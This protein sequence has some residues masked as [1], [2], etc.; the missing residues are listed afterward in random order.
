M[1]RTTLFFLLSILLVLQGLSQCP[2]DTAVN[3]G[4]PAMGDFQWSG[5]G[6]PAIGE[7]PTCVTFDRFYSWDLPTDTGYVLVIHG[8]F[9]PPCDTIEVRIAQDCRWVYK[10]TCFALPVTGSGCEYILSVDPPV[11]AQVLVYWRSSGTDSIGLIA[12]EASDGNPLSTIL[13]DMDTCIVLVAQ[14]PMKEIP[15]SREIY[16]DP[17]TMQR[18]G[19]KDMIPY[20]RYLLRKE[21]QPI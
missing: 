3:G 10:D 11:D 7:C 16:I 18:V 8:N 5:P 19:A 20:K 12:N 17:M 9:A 14:E 21:Y 2:H 13:Y 4:F 15:I 1:K 6:D